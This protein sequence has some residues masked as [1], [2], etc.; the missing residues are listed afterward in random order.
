[1]AEAAK[2]TAGFAVIPVGLY[3]DITFKYFSC[4]ALHSFPGSRYKLFK[5]L[6]RKIYRSICKYLRLIFAAFCRLIWLACVLRIFFLL[7]GLGL[8]LLFKLILSCRLLCKHSLMVYVSCRF[9]VIQHRTV[10]P[11]LIKC[12][13]LSL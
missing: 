10:H 1:M 13:K 8:C 3:I 11:E 6:L 4:I 2:A 12:K 7:S 9:T 5:F